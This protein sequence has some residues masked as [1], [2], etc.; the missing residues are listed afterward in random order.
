[1][2]LPKNKHLVI[3]DFDETLCKTNGLVLRSDKQ[4]DTKDLLTPAQY[5]DWRLTG[6]YNLDPSRWSFDFSDFTGYPSKGHPVEETMKKLRG[7]LS[8]PHYICALVTGRDELAGPKEFLMD[9]Y[10]EVDNMI[11]I[12]S[13]DPNKSPSFESLINTFE[14]NAVT[15][16]EDC[17]RSIEQCETVAAKYHIP[18]AS[19]LVGDG[20]VRWD[21]RSKRSSK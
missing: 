4:S 20:S 1:M 10:I 13:G 21:W 3:F 15:I 17:L 12:C 18:C 5:S 19:V 8:D 2:N 11:L 14:P 6:E 16:Y 7:Y 9:H